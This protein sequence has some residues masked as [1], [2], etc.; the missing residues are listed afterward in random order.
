MS[1]MYQMSELP[2]MYQYGQTCTGLHSYVRFVPCVVFV[3]F[4]CFV[5]FVRFVRFVVVWV[6]HRLWISGG[7]SWGENPVS[8]SR[9]RSKPFT[10]PLRC[11]YPRDTKLGRWRGF[12]QV[13]HRGFPQGL[14]ITFS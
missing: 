11:P 7:F 4:V 10:P 2:T 6:F 1:T 8:G 14:W 9:L 3:R 13:I 12:P 5:G